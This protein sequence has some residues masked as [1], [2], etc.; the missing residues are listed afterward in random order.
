MRGCRLGGLSVDTPG[1][2]TGRGGLGKVGFLDSSNPPRFPPGGLHLARFLVIW[3]PPAQIVELPKHNCVLT[4][5]A[6]PWARWKLAAIPQACPVS[7]QTHLAANSWLRE[8][9]RRSPGTTFLHLLPTHA[10]CCSPGE[11]RFTGGWL[12]GRG[13]WDRAGHTQL[14]CLLQRSL[15]KNCSHPLP[16]PGKPHVSSQTG[17]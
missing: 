1:G 7:T 2:Q 10:T 16:L 14:R 3:V 9:R 8:A 4:H 15:S 5:R 13:G 12:M 11:R 6:R 17:R